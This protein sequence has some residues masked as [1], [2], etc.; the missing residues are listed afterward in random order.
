MKCAACSAT[1]TTRAREPDLARRR[2]R[3]IRAQGAGQRAGRGESRFSSSIASASAASARA[4]KRSSGWIRARWPSSSATNIRRSSPSCLSYLEPDQAA[5]VL[6]F[7]PESMRPDLIMRI[8]T[9]DGVQPS[10]LTELDDM[11]EK[12]FAGR[13]QQW[14]ELGARRP[15]GRGRHGQPARLEGRQQLMS[16]R[17]QDRRSAVAEHPGPDVRVRRPHRDRRSRHAGAAAPGAGRQAAASRS[18]APTRRSRRRSS[19]TCRSARRR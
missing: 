17:R 16:R 2:R 14:Q 11:M 4:S 8:A 13:R 3:R 15:Q 7:L 18:R 10:A 6:A 12:Q 1:F 19:R 9:L 5:E